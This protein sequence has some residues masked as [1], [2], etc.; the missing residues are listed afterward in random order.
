MSFI[1]QLR[2]KITLTQE[3]LH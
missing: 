3:Y 1:V 2:T